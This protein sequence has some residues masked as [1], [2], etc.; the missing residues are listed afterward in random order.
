[1]F[2]KLAVTALLLFTSIV[3][4]N[5][6]AKESI[7]YQ[8]NSTQYEG[9]LIKPTKTGDLDGVSILLAHDFLGPGE[10]QFSLARQYAD[11]GALTFVADFYGASIRPASAEQAN[12]EA[13][14]VRGNI[15]ELRAAMQQA[16]SELV[17]HGGQKSKT[18]VIGTSVGGLAALE[19]AR[20]GESVNAVISLWGILENT[21]KQTTKDI[22]A[23]V[24]LL[25]GDLDPLTPMSAINNTV[26]ELSANNT[27]YDLVIYEKTAHAFTLPFMGQDPSTGFAYNEESAKNAFARISTALI[28]AAK[29]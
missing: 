26:A 3:G 22:K 17:K 15:P 24:V 8:T 25:Q 29:N 21:A 19:L 13:V 23:K 7:Q 9:Y 18:V 12:A 2:S 14:R 27:N 16:L 20:T 11:R 6:M 1:M 28:E 5:D 4:A 10:N